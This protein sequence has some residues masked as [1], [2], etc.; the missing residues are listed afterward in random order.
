M[1][2]FTRRRLLAETLGTT[3][4]LVLSACSQAPSTAAPT[5]TVPKPT[6]PPAAT[7][8]ATPAGAPTT[9]AAATTA[10]ASAPAP[11]QATGGTAGSAITFAIPSEP[12]TFDPAIE[13]AG[14]GYRVI[15][16]TYE[17]LLQYK[18]NTTQLEPALAESWTVSQDGSYIDLKLRQ[19]V[20]FH[21]G[22]ILD[23]DTVK[24]SIDRTKAVNKG[25]AFFLQVLKEVQVTDPMSVRLVATQPSVSLLYGLP[26]V[27][28]TGKAHLSDSDHGAAYFASQINGTGPYKLSRWDKGQQIVFDQFPGYWGGWSGNHVSQVIERVVPE[29]GTQEL[30]LER[31]D[32]HLVVLASIGITQ[33]PKDEASKPGIQ[34][35]ESPAFR[36]RHLDEHPERAAQGRSIAE[37]AP[38]RIRL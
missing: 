20:K 12:Q 14:P 30:M 22:A 33:D 27:Y 6:S 4:V 1:Q 35:V 3:G 13:V 15:K 16:Q 38:V 26:K 21:D 18:G 34:M 36:D 7:A 9:A 24:Q 23:A 37:G 19:N 32:A 8:A 2:L 5:Q 11:T 31:G 29:S 28:V 17:G 25:G 10:P